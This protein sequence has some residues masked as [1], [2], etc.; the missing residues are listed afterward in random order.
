L[1]ND[2]N[3]SILQEHKDYINI[4]K[5]GDYIKKYIVKVISENTTIT[6]GYVECLILSSINKI[7]IVIYNDSNNITNDN[8]S[9]YNNINDIINDL[10][11]RRLLE[12]RDRTVLYDPLVAPERRIDIRQYPIPLLKQI[13]IPTRGYPDNYQLIGLA[14]RNSDEK[15]L[16]LFG[17]PT[18]PGSNQYEYY[19][20]SESNG[21]VNKFPIKTK[22]QREIEDGS[23]IDVPF[24]M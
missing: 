12:H 21:F 11:V 1:N 13:N 22:G 9:Y 17:R 14:S 6:G 2:K 3:K 20:T 18:F 10:P 16:Q 7:P 23:L 15:V 8:S 5:T 19:V 24:L 4:K